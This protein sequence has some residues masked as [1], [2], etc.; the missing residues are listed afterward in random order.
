MAEVVLDGQVADMSAQFTA[1]M[2]TPEQAQQI[3]VIAREVV[4][5]VKTMSV[6]KGLQSEKGPDAVIDY[7]KTHLPDILGQ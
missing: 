6:P 1:S 7:G 2:W 4:P 3:I 5:K